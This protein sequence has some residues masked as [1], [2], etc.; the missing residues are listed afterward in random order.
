[1]LAKSVF[2]FSRMIEWIAAKWLVLDRDKTHVV[3]IIT[4][5]GRNP[6]FLSYYAVSGGN[7]LPTYGASISFPSSSIKD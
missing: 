4:K 2:G 7:F 6:A 1:V 3:E 5:R